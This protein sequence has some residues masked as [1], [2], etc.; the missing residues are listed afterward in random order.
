MLSRFSALRLGSWN[1]IADPTAANRHYGP[2]AQ[3][4][5]S[6]FGYDGIGTIGNDTTIASAD[7]D[8]VLCI[9]IQA[10][11]KRAS[12]QKEMIAKQEIEL[13][14]LRNMMKNMNAELADLRD[15]SNP[16]QQIQTKFSSK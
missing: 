7:I 10:L 4:W 16:P 11:E 6:A 14:E 3:Q 12:E 1:Y 5:F 9:A 13:N 2:M 15:R 8:G